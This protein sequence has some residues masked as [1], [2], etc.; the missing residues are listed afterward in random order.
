MCGFD[1]SDIDKLK[2]IINIGGAIR[3]DEHGLNVEYVIVGKP[4]L[5]EVSTLKSLE[6]Y[7][8]IL[9][10]QSLNIETIFFRQF[11]FSSSIVTVDWLVAC[12]N[13]KGIA[14][15]KEFL[16]KLQAS[17]SDSIQTVPSPASRKNI[18]AMN[19][20]R[21]PDYK[22]RS[23]NLDDDEKVKSRN[24]KTL[25][26]QY[27]QPPTSNLQVHRE[28][29]GVETIDEPEQVDPNL[30]RGLTFAL[31]GFSEES[32]SD[33]NS[34]IEDAGGLMVEENDFSKTVDYLVVPGDTYDFSDCHYTF[35]EKINDVWVVSSDSHPFPLQRSL[36]IF[37]IQQQECLNENK[38]VAV[39]YFHRAISLRQ[40]CKPL[41]G[42]KIVISI[43][44]GSERDYLSSLAKALGG[45]IN[46]RFM[47]NQSPILICP[48]PEGQKYLGAIKWSKCKCCYL[49]TQIN[50]FS[51]SLRLDLPVVSCDWLRKC[52][53]LETKVPMRNYAVGES[54]CEDGEDIGDQ[55]VSADGNVNLQTQK[56]E[57][58]NKIDEMDV[59][60]DEDATVGI[61]A[62]APA[63]PA[64]PAQHPRIS[65]IK[66]RN[67][68]SQS[69]K[70]PP[71]ATPSPADADKKTPIT[72]ECKR[73]SLS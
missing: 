54:K 34:E 16:Y 22:P 42:L 31:F 62:I 7:N 18:E 47:R 65:A 61:R 63:T 13:G 24:E 4:N 60:K 2:K 11:C 35:K 29:T 20:I 57:K 48:R 21:R 14:D 40:T 6:K 71:N 1:G 28:E 45:E 55:N 64:T 46:E 10:H 26:E 25:L 43:Y 15:P 68:R 58:V 23:L 59:G 72:G 3:L 19:P 51:F 36:C 69:P 38:L 67:N 50:E 12:I 27:A 73:W 52:H 32:T 39:E 41:S 49:D 30:F 53:E 66:N 37:G 70:T 8:R 56:F 44:M 9:F 17:N 5:A 33:L